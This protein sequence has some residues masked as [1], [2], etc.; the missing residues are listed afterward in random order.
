MG[1]RENR[2]VAIFGRKG[3]GKSTRAR[4]LV[5]DLPRVIVF[6]PMRDY[7]TGAVARSFGEAVDYLTRVRLGRYRLVLRSLDEQDELD[8]IALAVHGS[9]EHPLLPGATFLIDEADRLC[10]P[11]WMP[12]A[13][14]RAVNYGRHFGV[15]QIYVSRRPRRINRDITANAD[16]IHVGATQEPADLSYL[17]EFITRPLA[18]RARLIKRPG[19]FL[20]YPDDVPGWDEPDPGGGDG[21]EE[22]PPDPGELVELGEEE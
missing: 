15:S 20:V 22:A 8:L 9:P 7:P 21:E 10:S 12:P 18:D 5:A 4:S 13:L 2:V 11:N 14:H 1:A 17:A 6:D 3:F 19:E 16:E